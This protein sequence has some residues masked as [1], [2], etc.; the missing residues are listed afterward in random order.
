VPP[1]AAAPPPFL[2]NARLQAV[3]RLKEDIAALG[4]VSEAEEAAARGLQLPGGARAPTP[5]AA[6]G[7]AA[8]AAAAEAV[9]R[10][11]GAS[12]A[13]V[14]EADPFGL[15]DFLRKEEEKQQAT[16][17]R[18]A[19]QQAAAAGSVGASD[20]PAAPWSEA[21][22]SVMRRQALLDCVTA[23]KKMHKLAWARVR[24]AGG[25]A[26]GGRACLTAKI[27]PGACRTPCFPFR[28]PRLSPFAPFVLPPS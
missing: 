28:T 11:G 3:S 17:Q 21:E 9:D 1:R 6:A 15:D 19:A 27:P 4:P 20:D 18:A 10:E 12:A 26:G 7:A 5:A 16:W 8:A 13:A 2:P 24:Q 14:D 25:W 23:A 22:L